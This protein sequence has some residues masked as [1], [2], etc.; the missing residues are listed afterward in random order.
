MTTDKNDPWAVWDSPAAAVKTKEEKTSTRTDPTI[1]EGTHRCRI[2]GWR[3]FRSGPDSKYP[4]VFF[5]VWDFAILGGTFD[6]RTLV[7]MSSPF[8]KPGDD[9]EWQAKQAGW[10]KADLFTV[11]GRVPDRQELLIPDTEQSGPVIM[12]IVG[13]IVEV[14]LEWKR[15]KDGQRYANCHINQLIR[16]PQQPQ[17]ETKPE[18][19]PPTLPETP[20]R[21]SGIVDP[22]AGLEDIPF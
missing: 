17:D 19:E 4:G 1:P 21:G 3:F 9:E 11:L 10:V 20:S 8:G 14:R 6:G 22:E 12:E 2:V 15:A 5:I 18:T 16:G 13:A 7:K